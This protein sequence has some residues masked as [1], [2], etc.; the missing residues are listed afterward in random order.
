MNHHTSIS[1]QILELDHDSTV[2]EKKARSGLI[3]KGRAIIIIV[4]P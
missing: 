2:F 3:E 4:R 1:F